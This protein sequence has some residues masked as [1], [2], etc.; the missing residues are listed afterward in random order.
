MGY[1]ERTQEWD[2][3]RPS[4]WIDRFVEGTLTGRSLCRETLRL[5]SCV[6]VINLKDSGMKM[7]VEVVSGDHLRRIV[8]YSWSRRF[9][10]PDDH[11]G[12]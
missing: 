5:A 2:Q 4:F 9:F 6:A 7:E 10:E 11:L 8:D 3:E 12:V 1:Q